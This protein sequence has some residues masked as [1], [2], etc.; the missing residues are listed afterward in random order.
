MRAEKMIIYIVRHAWAEERNDKKWPD[1]GQRPLTEEGIKRFAAVAKTLVD[2]GV[3]PELIATSPL[4]RCR[5]TAEILA[6]ASPAK[7][8]VIDRDELEPGSDLDGILRWT[9]Q[10]AKRDQQVAWVGHSPD[11]DDFAA[12]LI[13]DSNASIRF[14]KGSVAAIEFDGFAE[15]GNGQLKWLVTAKILGF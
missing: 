10:T 15:V 11:V 7:P 8:K 4:V 6:A 3:V 12:E 9:N 5:Q 1:D 14:T 13:G 2:R